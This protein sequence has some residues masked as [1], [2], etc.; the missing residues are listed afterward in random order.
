MAHI[1]FSVSGLFLV[2]CKK[3]P[4]SNSKQISFEHAKLF[5]EDESIKP[6]A[7]MHGCYIFALRSGKGHTPW[8]IGKTSKSLSD[9]VF[10]T[11]KLNKFNKVLFD[12]K[13]GTPVMF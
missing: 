7:E 8:Y 12:D 5:W 1:Q 11:D 6:F 4:D 9:E 2:P 13:K 10:T 3:H